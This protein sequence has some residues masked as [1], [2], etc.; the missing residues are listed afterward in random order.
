VAVYP[1]WSG[2]EL[3]P[4]VQLIEH[5]ID[6]RHAALCV[7]RKEQPPTTRRVDQE[8]IEHAPSADDRRDV[9]SSLRLKLGRETRGPSSVP[10]GGAVDD[11]DLALGIHSGGIEAS[12]PVG[13]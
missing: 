3:S 8:H 13:N 7:F 11:L 12:P 10:S 1:R 4:A 5:V 9:E 2:D 6:R